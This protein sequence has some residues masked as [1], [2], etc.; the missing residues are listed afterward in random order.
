MQSVDKNEKEAKKNCEKIISAMSSL[1]YNQ[2]CK[3]NVYNARKIKYTIFHIYIYMHT[4]PSTY[5][6]SKSVY[7][8]HITCVHY[9]D[10][11]WLQQLCDTHINN[12]TR[13]RTLIFCNENFYDLNATNWKWFLNFQCIQQWWRHMWQLILL[14]IYRILDKMLPIQYLTKV[15]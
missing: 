14:K 2:K 4:P 5:T 6:T 9:S 13:G 3:W 8:I 11:S 7:F 15:P 12:M 10:K 1:Q